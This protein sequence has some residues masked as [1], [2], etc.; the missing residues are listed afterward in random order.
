MSAHFSP[1][2][3]PV[4]TQRRF[5][6]VA[7]AARTSPQ[8]LTTV[9]SAERTKSAPIE[10]RRECH[11]IPESLSISRIDSAYR[12]PPV[13]R[14]REYAVP[15]HRIRSDFAHQRRPIQRVYST[16]REITD[17]IIHPFE[18]LTAALVGLLAANNVGSGA[19]LGGSLA[20]C[21]IP[22]GASM[23]SLAALQGSMNVRR[24]TGR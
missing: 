14:I 7:S 15:Q 22:T 4:T 23:K 12:M 13:V 3:S 1:G 20:I 6:S 18:A 17:W 21:L 24:A 10:S 8:T 11:V 5:S 16:N 9:P 19:K 2:S